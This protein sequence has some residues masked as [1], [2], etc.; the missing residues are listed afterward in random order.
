MKAVVS[1]VLLA[2]FAIASACLWDFDTLSMEARGMPDVVDAVVGRFDRNP[3]LYYEMR[4]ARVTDLVKTEPENLDLYDDAAVAC[5]K[6]GRGIEGL[7][8]LELKRNRLEESDPDRKRSE[9]WYRYFAN[10]GTLRVH[11]WAKSGKKESGELDKAISEIEEAIS[12][13][14][15]AHFGREW[16]Q[17]TLM[18]TIKAQLLE[19]YESASDVLYRAQ[20]KKTRE[21]W[22]TGLTGLITLGA[23]WESIDVLMAIQ[24]KGLG[25]SDQN[26]ATLIGLRVEELKRKGAQSAFGVDGERLFHFVRR[27][28]TLG[29]TDMELSAAYAALRK[30]ADD[31]HESRTSFMLSRLRDGRHPDTDPTFWDGY[32]ALERPDLRKFEPFIPR[33]WYKSPTAMIIIAIGGCSSPF[34]ALFIVVRRRAVKRRRAS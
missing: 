13:N 33:A 1:I 31:Y 19:G 22:K 24:D 3:P 17:L 8:W 34:I 18:R 27:G 5:D 14:P 25:R 28:S 11:H 26:V 10:V 30:N 16:V 9:D 12:I 7:A 2:A 21:E 23:A 32:V 29:Q 15:D 4:L 20:D 6:L